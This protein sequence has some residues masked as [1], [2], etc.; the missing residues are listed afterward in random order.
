MR[1]QSIPDLFD[2]FFGE[3]EAPLAAHTGVRTYQPKLDL[4]E[5]ADHYEVIAD[6][7]GVTREGVEVEFE[8]GVLEIRGERAE[9]SSGDDARWY[10][11]ERSRGEFA[12][13]IAFRD[14]VEVGDIE[15]TVKDGVL[16]VR[17]PKTERR[18]PR[19]IPV[20]VH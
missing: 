1:N 5:T 12:R 11:R 10:R 16:R 20:T 18:K 19:Q 15:A 7:P 13:A 6:L 9:S 14:D 8:N 17:L 2:R 4:V 3:L